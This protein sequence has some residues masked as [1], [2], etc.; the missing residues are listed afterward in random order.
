MG[1]L[2][3]LKINWAVLRPRESTVMLT[4]YYIFEKLFKHD[5]DDIP[6]CLL[7]LIYISNELVNAG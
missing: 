1:E 2:N 3:D 6:A 4:I 7:L 5:L